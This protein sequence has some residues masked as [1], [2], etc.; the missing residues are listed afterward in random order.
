MNSKESGIKVGLLVSAFIA[1]YFYL[2]FWNVTGLVQYLALGLFVA[3]IA[4]AVFAVRPKLVYRIT[5]SIIVIIFGLLLPRFFRQEVKQQDQV[6]VYLEDR[7]KLIGKW[8]TDTIGGYS[9]ALKIQNDSAN[10]S[11]SN[12]EVSKNFAWNINDDFFEL[13]NEESDQFFSWRF[14]FIENDNT[15]MLKSKNDTLVFKKY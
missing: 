7:K 4:Y 8:K 3:V 15:L 5:I 13:V 11:Q 1:F 9:I 12:L 14:E 6:E 10:L 2:K